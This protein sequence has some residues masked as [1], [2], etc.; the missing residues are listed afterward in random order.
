MSIGDWAK[1]CQW[2]LACESG[3]PTLLSAQT[4]Q[5]ITK[6]YVVMDSRGGGIALGWGV[7]Y[8]DYVG[9]RILGHTGS[10]GF[11]Y[12]QV[13]LVHDSRYGVIVMTNQGNGTVSNPI[14]PVVVRLIQLH[15]NGN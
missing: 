5:T 12:A 3:H 15:Q 8:W 6:A 13:L 2:V 1:Y 10:N 9:G 7:E 11:N 14:W 4:A